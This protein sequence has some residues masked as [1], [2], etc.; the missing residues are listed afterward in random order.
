MLFVARNDRALQVSQSLRGGQYRLGEGADIES[1]RKKG[2][3]VID[4]TNVGDGI[5]STN[6]TTFATSKTVMD[7][8]RSGS[9]NKDVLMGH[10][11]NTP[12][13]PLGDGIGAVTDLAS[14]IIYLPA[15]IVGVR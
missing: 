12:L 2:I 7:L 4:L 11:K 9:L 6:H 14:G 15:K 10:Q 8:A 5:D 3:T 1:L 13:K